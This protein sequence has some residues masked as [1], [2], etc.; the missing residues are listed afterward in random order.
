VDLGEVAQR[1][2]NGVNR[3]AYQRAT[4]AGRLS[5]LG[6]QAYHVLRSEL[7]GIENPDLSLAQLAVNSAVR[8]LLPFARREWELPR[9]GWERLVVGV[10]IAIL[11]LEGSGLKRSQAVTAAREAL[12]E[13]ERQQRAA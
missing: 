7:G 3:A 2:G 9:D 12:V 5:R 6:S 4:R 11:R 13:L 1:A 10:A 8:D